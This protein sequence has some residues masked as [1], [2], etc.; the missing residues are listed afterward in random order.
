[1]MKLCIPYFLPRISTSLMSLVCLVCW[2]A[3]VL[4]VPDAEADVCVLEEPEHLNFF[5]AEGVPWLKKFE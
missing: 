5:R 4:Q 3:F 1:M 2:C